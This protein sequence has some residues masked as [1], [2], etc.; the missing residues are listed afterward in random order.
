MTLFRETVEPYA[1]IIAGSRTC[2]FEDLTGAIWSD[3]GIWDLVNRASAIISGGAIGA[4]KAGERLA[5]A[6]PGVEL[7]VMPADWDRYGKSAGFRRNEE[8][9][10]VGD[11]LLAVW[12][13]KSRGTKHMIETMARLDKEY[14]VYVPG[15]FVKNVMVRKV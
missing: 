7:V 12:D 10:K 13:G 8:M 1:L 11:K 2:T 9:A 3:W 14:R 5:M 4:D 6:S 15:R